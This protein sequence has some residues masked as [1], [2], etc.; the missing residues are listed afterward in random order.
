MQYQLVLSY[1]DI[2][3]LKTVRTATLTF[4]FTLMCL[5]FGSKKIVQ[6]HSHMR[7]LSLRSV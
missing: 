3:H 5:L 7:E 2:V 6:L 4:T 1:Y